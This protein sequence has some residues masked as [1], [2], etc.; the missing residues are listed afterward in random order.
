MVVDNA[1]LTDNFAKNGC[2]NTHETVATPK[3]RQTHDLSVAFCSIGSSILGASLRQIKIDQKL[4]PSWFCVVREFSRT[5]QP[6]QNL[7]EKYVSAGS[8]E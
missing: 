5:P 6:I 1:K 3:S 4:Q 7:R 8:V 2:F